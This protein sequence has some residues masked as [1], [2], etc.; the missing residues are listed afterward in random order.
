MARL[1]F[2]TFGKGLGRVVSTG[3]LAFL[4]AG[5]PYEA[6]AD[7]CQITQQICPN[8]SWAVGT[9]TDWYPVA[10]ADQP[11]CKQRAFDFY[12]WCGIPASSGQTTTANYFNA[13]TLV[14]STM[15]GHTV[16]QITQSSCPN[17]PSYIGNFPD[18]YRVADTNQDICLSRASD[19]Y[20]WCGSPQNSSTKATYFENGQAIQFK[21][22]GS[23]EPLPQNPF[24]IGSDYVGFNAN[25]LAQRAEF[26]NAQLQNAAIL[27]GSGGYVR[28]W[29]HIGQ[30][31]TSPQEQGAA[32]CA[33]AVQ[34]AHELNQVPV[35]VIQEAPYADDPSSDPAIGFNDYTTY[36]RAVANLVSGLS[37]PDGRVLWIEMANE[38]NWTDWWLSKTCS[39][40]IRA[41]QV[42]RQTY[43]TIQAVRS[44]GDAK[45][46]ILGPALAPYGDFDPNPNAGK[47][48]DRERGIMGLSSDL[49]LN[50]MKLEVPQL[51]SPPMYDAWNSHAYPDFVFEICSRNGDGC[52]E[53]NKQRGLMGYRSELQTVGLPADFP[54]IL[55]EAG[56]PDNQVTGA[57]FMVK[58]NGKGG[59]MGAYPEVWLSQGPYNNVQAVIGYLLG[60]PNESGYNWM[61]PWDSLGVFPEWSTLTPLLKSV[62]TY[63]NSVLPTG[64][65]SAGRYHLPSGTIFYANGVGQVCN[66]ASWNAYLQGGGA[67]D[68]SNVTAIIAIPYGNTLMGICQ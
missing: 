48:C 11:T 35:V 66:Y 41:H 44:I 42:A 15:I 43:Q 55:T 49:F 50:E 36:S 16:C 6:A 46:K 38:P 1:L 59:W 37:R 24:G 53:I 13:G 33:N 39:Y 61:D 7:V 26:R 62:F 68:L 9:F 57:E 20:N 23:Y 58:S 19:Y 21:S 63:R 30:I 5:A 32:E 14:E 22:V 34:R 65:L 2:K 10:N 54:I 12:N 52:A 17:H 29:C 31:W 3:M 47:S 64:K 60:S 56:Y 40:K 45:I 25:S 28:I 67:A 27:T 18:S 51:F 4:I 8:Y